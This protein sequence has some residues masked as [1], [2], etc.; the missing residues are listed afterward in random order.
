MSSPDPNPL[1]Y[2]APPHRP[3]WIKWLMIGIV[4]LFILVA[5]AYGAFIL[6]AFHFSARFPS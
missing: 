1:D 6:I 4:L 2:A 3:P 5:L